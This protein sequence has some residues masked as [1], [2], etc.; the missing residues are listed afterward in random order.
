MDAREGR[1]LNALL[2]LDEGLNEW[3]V[4]FIESLDRN[5]RERP[6]SDA[7]QGKLWQ[8]VKDRQVTAF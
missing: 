3:E 6:L 8:I 1:A 2:D 4:G 5:F 7:Q